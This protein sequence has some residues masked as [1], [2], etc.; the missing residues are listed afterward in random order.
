[1]PSVFQTDILRALRDFGSLTP[2]ELADGDMTTEEGKLITR[3]PVTGPLD[4]IRADCGQL[5]K[6]GYIEDAGMDDR[7][8]K[9][10]ITAKGHEYLE[11]RSR[12]LRK[13]IERRQSERR[14]S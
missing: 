7:E 14:A 4:G 3:K 9:Y 8:H 11:E 5:R 13:D 2:V 12:R 10:A 1:M 6:S